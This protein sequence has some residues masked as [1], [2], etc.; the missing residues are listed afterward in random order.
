MSLYKGG[1]KNIHGID[2]NPK[3]KKMP[4][5]DKINYH[6]G[7]FFENKFQ[8]S[9]FDCI[10]SISVIEHGYNEELFFSQFS[11]LLKKDGYL[12]LTFDYWEKKIET[13]NIKMFN[14]DWKI[15]SKEEV[16]SMIVHASK[17][18]N[19]EL[20]GKE[21]YDCVDTVINC[22]SK[23]YTFAWMVFKKTN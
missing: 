21:N 23:D 2:T 13:E 19:L 20:I 4:F 9:F 16:K 5:S 14:L 8:S 6:V 1:F 11:R 10:T 12:I 22:A 17:K 18:Y 15:F 7:N 3:I